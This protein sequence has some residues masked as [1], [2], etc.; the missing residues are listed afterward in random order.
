M[1]RI[2]THS[3]HF[4]AE[5]LYAILN[6][7]CRTVGIGSIIYLVHSAQLRIVH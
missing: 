4:L 6:Y 7:V 2:L 3:E 5:K 1:P